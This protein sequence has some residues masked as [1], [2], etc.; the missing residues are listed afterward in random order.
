MMQVDEVG[1]TQPIDINLCRF[2]TAYGKTWWM[3]TSYRVVA[4]PAGR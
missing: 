2:V 1:F 4:S 3:P